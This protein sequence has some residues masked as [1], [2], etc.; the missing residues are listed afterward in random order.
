MVATYVSIPAVCFASLLIGQAAI[1]LC[2]RRE[3]SWLSPAV[4][5]SLLLWLVWM[6]ARLPGEGLTAGLSALG[7]SIAA[8]AYLRGR[9]SGLGNAAR[10]GLPVGALALLAVSIPFIAEGHF[11]ILGTSF[12]PDMSQHLLAATR[13]GDGD[14]SQLSTQGYPLGPHGIAVALEGGLGVALVQGFS[15]LTAAVSILAALTALGLFTDARPVQRTVGALLVGLPYMVVS[16]LAQGAFKETMQALF[17]LAFA[18]AL[19]E[20]GRGR[21][22]EDR[23]LAAIPLA[24]IAAGSVFAYSFA[25]L[26]W[27]LGAAGVWAVVVLIRRRDM[28]RVLKVSARPFAFTLVAFAV[29]AGPEFGRMLDFREFETFDPA[30]PGLGNLFGQISPFESLGIWPSGDFRLTP[31]DGAVPAFGYYLGA[32][33]GLVLLLV[34]LIASVRAGAVALPSALA[35][36]AAIY[37]AARIGGTPYQAAKAV[38]IAAPVAMAVIVVPLVTS[39]IPLPSERGRLGYRLAGGVFA[40]VALACSVLALANAPVGPTDYSSKLTELR[41][42]VGADSTFV[43]ASDELLDEQHGT[44]YLAWELRGGRV[45]IAPEWRAGGPPPRG[46]RFV[47]TDAG[48]GERPPFRS[49]RLLRRPAPYLLWERIGPIERRSDCPLI[50]VREARR[51]SALD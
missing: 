25:G 51:G 7:A 9:V 11:G 29:L 47:I 17:V 21:P 34:G 46:V 13:L 3:W 43:L 22:S 5:L 19:H 2:G 24:L 8:G 41:S 31:G 39:Q 30:G 6:T 50:A 20:A 28:L 12:N 38:E 36:A 32:A 35:A 48:S 1:A 15:G 4:G 33:L 16:Y 45:C 10:A 26:A 18:L 49:L 14:A 40:V 37:L 23:T 44:P 27:L 42:L